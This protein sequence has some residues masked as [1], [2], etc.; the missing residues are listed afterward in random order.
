MQQLALHIEDGDAEDVVDCSFVPID[1]LPVQD[2]RRLR[3]SRRRPPRA[4]WLLLVAGIA[5]SVAV[6]G[7]RSA[8]PN[9]RPARHEVPRRASGPRTIASGEP[10]ANPTPARHRTAPR[11]R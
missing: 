5:M 1:A 8:P 9:E 10:R 2:P 6:V 7:H 3:R 11:V 4:L